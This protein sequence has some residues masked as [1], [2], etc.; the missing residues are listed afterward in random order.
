M[1]TCCASKKVPSTNQQHTTNRRNTVKTQK[2][3]RNTAPAGNKKAKSKGVRKA[4]LVAQDEPIRPTSTAFFSRG[5][6][7]VWS[8]GMSRLV[9]LEPKKPTILS[10]RV[11]ALTGGAR[12]VSGRLPPTFNKME[13]GFTF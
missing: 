13:R 2:D 7:S 6:T 10:K 11:F 3:S 5:S 4:A 1:F 8:S 9:G 12:D